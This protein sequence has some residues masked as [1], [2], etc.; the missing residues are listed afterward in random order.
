MNAASCIEQ[1]LEATFHKAT[2]VQPPASHLQNHPSLTN[3]DKLI[4]DILLWT[5][6]HG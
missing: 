4:S 1:I 2:A 5:S 3:K 6:S